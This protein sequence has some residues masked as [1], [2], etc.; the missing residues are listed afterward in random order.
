MDTPPKG[1]S[2][3]ERSAGSTASATAA[4]H[5]AM[6]DSATI[7]NSS[8]LICIFRFSLALGPIPMCSPLTSPTRRPFQPLPN[9]RT[10]CPQPP[11]PKLAPAYLLESASR[12]RLPSNALGLPASH[13]GASTMGEDGVQLINTRRGVGLTDSQHLHVPVSS[14]VS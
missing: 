7:D 2:L 3:D 1:K 8:T 13:S 11:P 6:Y 5:F 4:E 12:H 14:H 9:V 10:I